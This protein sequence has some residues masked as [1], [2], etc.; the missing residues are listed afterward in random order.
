VIP[1]R[2]FIRHREDR[3]VRAFVRGA[4][5][6]AAGAIAGATFVLARGAI[7]EIPTFLIALGSLAYLWR[8]KF[9]LKEPALVFVTGAI[10]LLM[11]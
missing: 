7:F 3:R 11:H 10:G 8:L 2:W 6:G 5:A 4:T 1:G 9:K